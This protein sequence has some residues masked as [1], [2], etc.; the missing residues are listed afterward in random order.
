[1]CLFPTAA[2]WRGPLLCASQSAIQHKEESSD[3][4]AALLSG[5]RIAVKHSSISRRSQNTVD[6]LGGPQPGEH[7]AAGCQP[8]YSGGFGPR[9]PTR[10][11][12]PDISAVHQRTMA[13]S[14][15]WRSFA[16]RLSGCNQRAI[17]PWPIPADLTGTTLFSQIAANCQAARGVA[18]F[19]T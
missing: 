8:L 2:C 12:Q 15:Q 19:Y 1:M 10:K 16:Y 3:E 17:L 13:S 5:S 6:I 9:P 14:S 7:V 4:A 11:H 18:S